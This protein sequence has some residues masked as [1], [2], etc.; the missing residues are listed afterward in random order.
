MTALSSLSLQDLKHKLRKG[1]SGRDCRASGLHRYAKLNEEKYETMKKTKWFIALLIVLFVGGC[2]DSR[3]KRVDSEEVEVV[4]SLLTDTLDKDS[5]VPSAEDS[6]IESLLSRKLAS[7]SRY[8]F[9]LKDS[10]YNGEISASYELTFDFPRSSVRNAA[11]IR[12][13]LAMKITNSA[14]VEN[15]PGFS[16]NNNRKIAQYAAEQYMIDVKDQV[17]P[18]FLY[19]DTVVCKEWWY[20]LVDLHAKIC[21]DKFVT[22]RYF[23]DNYTGGAH[24]LYT[25]KFVSFDPIHQQEIDNNYLFLPDSMDDVLSVLLEEAKKTSQY[26]EWHP[27]LVEYVNQ[28]DFSLPTPGL[29]EDGVVF[30]FQPYAISC[31]AAGV[32]HFPVPYSRIRHCLTPQAMWCIGLTD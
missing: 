10:T 26:K 19:E 21:T 11:A 5:I 32:F 6:L 25:E 3:S 27:T 29:Y 8:E 30:S 12:K 17:H 16:I 1:N 7:F 15:I 2:G 31:F 9:N 24:S 18:P 14:A 28:E 13:W 23:F 4:E 22:Y 20:R